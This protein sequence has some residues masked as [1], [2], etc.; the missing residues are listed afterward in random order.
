RAVLDP[1]RRRRT[2]GA[3]FSCV[4]PI[5]QPKHRRNDEQYEK[6]ECEIHES[7]VCHS[8][9]IANTYGARWRRTRD[10]SHDAKCRAQITCF[11]PCA[12][13]PETPLA[14]SPRCPPVSCASC[15]P[16]AFP[17]ACACARYRRRSTLPTRSC[18]EP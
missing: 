17:A 18:V 8:L 3:T 10:L 2:R 6:D 16:S 7:S 14:G 4:K 13:L 9:V 12:T 15:P 5:E 11:R 1:P